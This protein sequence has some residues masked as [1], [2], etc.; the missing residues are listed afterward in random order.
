MR[1]APTSWADPYDPK[2]KGRVIVPSLQN[3]EGLPNL[4]VASALATGQPLEA[5]QRDVEPGFRKLATLKP[6]LLTVYTQQPRPITCWSRAR[7]G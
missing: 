3:T 4:F 5:A 7:R 1:R 2:D 6:N